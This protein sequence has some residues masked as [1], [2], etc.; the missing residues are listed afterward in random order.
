MF[1]NLNTFSTI[2]A[3]STVVGG[4]G[5]A[6]Y[7][8]REK[9]LPNYISEKAKLI[10]NSGINVK[11]EDLLKHPTIAWQK[12][13]EKKEEEHEMQ[14]DDPGSYLLPETYEKSKW[15]NDEEERKKYWDRINEEIKKNSE[16]LASARKNFEIAKEKFKS[17]EEKL[18][19]KNI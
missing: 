7:L 19:G 14:S 2:F 5:T 17:L 3:G 15:E 12:I 11:S 6:I 16:L 1:L 4:T 18:S 8:N 9:I 13:T 10:K